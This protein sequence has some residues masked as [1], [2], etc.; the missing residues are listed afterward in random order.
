MPLKIRSGELIKNLEDIANLGK[1]K[2]SQGKPNQGTLLK[3]YCTDTGFDESRNLFIDQKTQIQ[4]L[5]LSTLI[6]TEKALIE[7]TKKK[8]STTLTQED[9]G[10]KTGGDKSGAPHFFRRSHIPSSNHQGEKA[11]SI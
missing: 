3:S 1:K 10:F 5:E 2:G 8:A 11:C 7:A 6:N 9:Q 4:I